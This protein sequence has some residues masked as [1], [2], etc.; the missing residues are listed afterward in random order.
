MQSMNKIILEY[1]YLETNLLNEKI[2]FQ[3]Q[4]FIVKMCDDNLSCK[5]QSSSNKEKKKKKT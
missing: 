4:I 3:V 1:I 5:S 2:W